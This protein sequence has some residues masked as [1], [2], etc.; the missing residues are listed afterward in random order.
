[1]TGQV[2]GQ[3]QQGA[4]M[5]PHLPQA[6][7]PGLVHLL[8]LLGGAVEGRTAAWGCAARLGCGPGGLR[9]PG[10]LVLALPD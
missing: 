1:M 8:V 9:R 7:P 5:G 4:E 2:R 3:A 10:L 6:L